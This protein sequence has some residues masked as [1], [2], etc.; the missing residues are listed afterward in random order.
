LTITI[1]FA[2][3]VLT[4]IDVTIRKGIRALSMSKA[5]L[6]FT[7]IPVPIL[8]FMY[9]IA[10]SFILSPLPDV[11]V[12]VITFPNPVAMLDSLRPLTIIGFAINP[13]VQT[14]TINFAIRIV[15]QILVSVT[16]FLVALAVPLVKKPTSLVHAPIFINTYAK[17]LSLLFYDLSSIERVFI[18]F[19]RKV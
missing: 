1:S 6:P 2:I 10:M 18:A 14:F 8:P 7:F 11:R 16:K 13:S 15:P 17:A 4:E 19:D 9:T 3:A 5:E 12:A